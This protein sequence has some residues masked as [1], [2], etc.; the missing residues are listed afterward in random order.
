MSLEGSFH[1]SHPP[2]APHSRT[3]RKIL[4]SPFFSS[5]L[6]KISGPPRGSTE[7]RARNGPPRTDSKAG[8]IRFSRFLPHMPAKITGGGDCKSTLDLTHYLQCLCERL[9]ISGTERAL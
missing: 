4:R 5:K 2:N 7:V 6:K 9:A 3:H 8:S 1:A